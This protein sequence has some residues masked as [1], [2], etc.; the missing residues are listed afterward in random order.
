M[1]DVGRGEGEGGQERLG[2]ACNFCRALSILLT[3]SGLESKEESYSWKGPHG[4]PSAQGRNLFL[5]SQTK[6]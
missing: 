6:G 3:N 1:M 2:R 5:P 4:Q